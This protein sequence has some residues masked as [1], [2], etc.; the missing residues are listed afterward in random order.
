MSS[1]SVCARS[2][3]VDEIKQAGASSLALLSLYTVAAWLRMTQPYAQSAVSMVIYST[4]CYII[5]I[6]NLCGSESY[7]AAQ[8]PRVR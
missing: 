6:L 4:K 2:L 8:G 7:R 1:Y 3:V 5:V